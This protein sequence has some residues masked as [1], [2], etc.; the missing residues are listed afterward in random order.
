MGERVIIRHMEPEKFHREFPDRLEKEPLALRTGWWKKFES[1]F[2]AFI[3]SGK[4][5]EGQLQKLVGRPTVIL[6]PEVLG[7]SRLEIRF[8]GE[9]RVHFHQFYNTQGMVHGLKEFEAVEYTTVEK[10]RVLTRRE[11]FHEDR[12]GRKGVTIADWV[13]NLV[14]YWDYVSCGELRETIENFSRM[15][16]DI[17]HLVINEEAQ[18]LLREN[19]RGECPTRFYFA[20]GKKEE[21]YDESYLEVL[22]QN[23]YYPITTLGRF[24]ESLRGRKKVD[25]RKWL[26]RQY[27]IENMETSGF[28]RRHREEIDRIIQYNRVILPIHAK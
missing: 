14:K 17:R 27:L 3:A 4:N 15:R 11:V 5:W 2:A 10:V 26:A 12:C 8:H 9:S 24:R 23:H 22:R 16:E 20:L 18:K 19:L 13:N 1:R 25:F 6:K 28:Y 21:D 7:D